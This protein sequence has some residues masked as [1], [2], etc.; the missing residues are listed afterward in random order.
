MKLTLS[1][2]HAVDHIL[3][4]RPDCFSRAGAT[5]LVEYMEELE[6]ET[7]EDIELDVIALCCDYSE[8]SSL[9]EAAKDLAGH[10]KSTT[11]NWYDYFDLDK[12]LNED[13]DE[14]EI[15]NHLREWF[16]DRTAVIEFDG[17]VIV[18]TF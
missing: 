7:G 17:G 8:Y 10:Y 3:S 6:K 16:T 4:I 1:T 9:I 18:S 5:A 2:S 13:D 15:T 11:K 12:D 14:E